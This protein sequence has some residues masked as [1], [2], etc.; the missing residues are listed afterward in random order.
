MFQ[1]TIR[2]NPPRHEY[3][4][5]PFRDIG[6]TLGGKLKGWIDPDRVASAMFDHE[7][8]PFSGVIS[9]KRERRVARNTIAIPGL[10]IILS[11]ILLWSRS[12]E[13]DYRKLMQ[14]FSS[15]NSSYLQIRTGTGLDALRWTTNFYHSVID[16]VQYSYPPWKKG[17]F[18]SA[19]D[20]HPLQNNP[21]SVIYLCL[22]SSAIASCSKFFL[23]LGVK[24]SW[25]NWKGA[26]EKSLS[27]IYNA[28]STSVTPNVDTYVAFSHAF[29]MEYEKTAKIKNIQEKEKLERQQLEKHI[30]NIFTTTESEEW[31]LFKARTGK[32]H[33]HSIIDDYTIGGRATADPR[34]K[35]PSFLAH[36]IGLIGWE[37]D[38]RE[39]GYTTKIEQHLKK[40]INNKGEDCFKIALP[41]PDENDEDESAEAS[42]DEFD[43]AINSEKSNVS[44]ND[45]VDDSA[46][47]GKRPKRVRQKEK[48]NYR[49]SRSKRGK[50]ENSNG[51]KKKRKRA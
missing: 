43:T 24:A 34:T 23:S 30:N 33:G 21:A 29:R 22:L 42:P 11:Q 46:K 28:G 19:D 37:D 47:G 20:R 32:Q 5:F 41:A 26:L 50:K 3:T 16:S 6:S 15:H 49:E 38:F 9:D 17:Y 45:T 48:T 8:K 39:A 36:I 14:L 1:Q 2:G 25:Q 13:E 7:N 4:I 12:C 35:D 51:P 40:I 31:E 27:S 44:G 18:V 10:V